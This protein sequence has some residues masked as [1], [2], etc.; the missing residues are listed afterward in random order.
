[1]LKLICVKLDLTI[2]GLF[3]MMCVHSS[4]KYQAKIWLFLDILMQN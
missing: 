4:R 2:V 3:G 1:M